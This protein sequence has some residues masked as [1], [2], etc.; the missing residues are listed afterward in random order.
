[1]RSTCR[2]CKGS[3]TIIQTPCVECEGKGTIIQRKKVT[4]PV[5]AGLAHQAINNKQ[6]TLVN[7]IRKVILYYN[8]N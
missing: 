5:P 4:V 7:G 6:T 1:M 2:Q 3:R 8:Y